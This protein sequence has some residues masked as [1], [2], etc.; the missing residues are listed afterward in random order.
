MYGIPAPVMIGTMAAPWPEEGTTTAA[1]PFSTIWFAQSWLEAGSSLAAQISSSIGCP[2]I[3]PRWAL[4]YSAAA[5]AARR[6]SGI[7]IAGPPSGLI[8]PI[9]TGVPVA[10]LSGNALLGASAEPASALSSVLPHAVPTT[11]AEVTRSNPRRILLTDSL[12]VEPNI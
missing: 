6:L 1:T 5:S 4:A 3:P 9:L 8:T 2:P 12:R 7:E 11:S 10:G